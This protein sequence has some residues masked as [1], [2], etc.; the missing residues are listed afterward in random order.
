MGVTNWDCYSCI[1]FGAA[2]AISLPFYYFSYEGM[3]EKLTKFVS[4]YWEL[5]HLKSDKPGN[6]G[7]NY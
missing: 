7:T 2:G 6:S 5:N 3:A 1:I 4:M